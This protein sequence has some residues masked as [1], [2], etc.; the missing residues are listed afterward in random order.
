MSDV[1]AAPPPNSAVERIC[2][3]IAILGGFVSLALAGTVCISVAGRKFFNAGVP[4]DFEFVQIGTALAVFAF[5]PLGQARRVN[6]VVD[7]FSTGW[8]AR[9][10]RIVD[11]I[12]DL[13]YAAMMGV[14]GYCMINGSIETFRNNTGSMVLQLPLWPALAVCTSLCL[15]LSGVTL[16]TAK[17]LLAARP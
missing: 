3:I 5:L 11:A 8:S 9:T 10:R 1:E 15:F 4:G 17:R 12:W 16:W 14:I 7:T 6:I 13:T 2:R